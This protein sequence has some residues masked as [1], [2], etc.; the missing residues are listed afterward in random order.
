M[1][2]GGVLTGLSVFL[3]WIRVFLGD[4]NLI[5]G[6]NLG[7]SGWLWIPVLL[8]EATAAFALVTAFGTRAV[9]SRVFAVITGILASLFGVVFIIAGNSL[10]ANTDGLAGISIG[11]YAQ[12]AGSI[13]VIV[14]ALSKASAQPQPATSYTPPPPP[15]PTPP[16]A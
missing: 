6:V 14:G 8:I 1:L 13:L 9:A 10:L 16:Q 2:I 4:V 7:Q 3:P 15:P 12:V 5:Q 11:P